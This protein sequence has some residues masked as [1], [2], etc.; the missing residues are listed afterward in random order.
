VEAVNGCGTPGLMGG[1][2]DKSSLI[3]PAHLAFLYIGLQPNPIYKLLF[4]LIQLSKS[5]SL[6]I[7]A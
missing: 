1:K 5:N 6:S 7:G 3:V 4:A 2:F